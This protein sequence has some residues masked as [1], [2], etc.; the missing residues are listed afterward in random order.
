M[1]L[2]MD[3]INLKRNANEC[4]DETLSIWMVGFFLFHMLCSCSIVYYGREHFISKNFIVFCIYVYI[5]IYIYIYIKSVDDKNV[6][7]LW[8]DDWLKIID[9]PTW[10]FKYQLKLFW[11]ADIYIYIL[12]FIIIYE[13][14]Q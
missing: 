8:E 5:Y 14:P 4:F 11:I 7:I 1:R 6:I 2:K 12:L 10:N 9:P 13:F 3:V